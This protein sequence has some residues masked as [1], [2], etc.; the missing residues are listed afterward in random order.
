[1]TCIIGAIIS[2]MAIGSPMTAPI[3]GCVGRAGSCAT[4]RPAASAP[5]HSSDMR[6]MVRSPGIAVNDNEAAALAGC[7]LG[8]ELTSPMYD[9]ATRGALKG[10]YHDLD[11][12]YSPIGCG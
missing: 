9:S 10:R 12:H 2:C 7:R 5:T 8:G 11:S 1:M 6:F 3:L 4:S